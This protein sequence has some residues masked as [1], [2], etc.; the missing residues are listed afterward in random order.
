MSTWQILKTCL[1]DDLQGKSV[2]D[3]GCNAGFY[4]IEAKRRNAGRV[5]GVDVQRL[6]IRQARFVNRVLGLDIAFERISVYDLDPQKIGRFDVTMALG[7]IYHCK[8]VI[9]ALEKLFHITKETLI[10]E[11]AVFPPSV[12]FESFSKPEWG[13]GRRFHAAAYVENDAAAKEAV[14]NWFVPTTECLCAMLRDV[15]FVDVKAVSDESGR[16]VIVGRRPENDADSLTMPHL[17]AARL[18][19]LEAPDTCSTG[20]AVSLRVAVSNTGQC[21]WLQRGEGANNAGSVRLGMH[22]FDDTGR[23]LT[24]DYASVPIRS[25]IGPGGETILDIRTTAPTKP[26]TYEL[27]FD[28]V[29]EHLT[30]FEDA[31][32]TIPAVHR[33]TVL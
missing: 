10:L 23:E 6:H 5:L 18:K 16:A 27:E 24:R 11:S 28:M 31:G 30:W 14:Y 20:S 17:A 21:T 4:S 26:G 32:S 15:G 3:V 12:L 9:L 8:H 1:P 13:I 7:L 22:L 25:S 2:L 19:V 33:L 29:S